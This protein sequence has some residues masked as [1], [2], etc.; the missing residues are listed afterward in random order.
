[1]P[2]PGFCVCAKKLGPMNS[3]EFHGGSPTPPYHHPPSPPKF[4]GLFP[5]GGGIECPFVPCHQSSKVPPPPPPPSQQHSWASLQISEAGLSLF[6]I[7]GLAAT[8]GVFRRCG[9]P[10]PALVAC[11]PSNREDT[12]LRHRQGGRKK[13]SDENRAGS[14]R[15]VGG[16]FSAPTLRLQWPSHSDGER[17]LGVLAPSDA[18]FVWTCRRW[19]P[20]PGTFYSELLRGPSLNPF[21]N[22]VGR[23]SVLLAACAEGNLWETWNGGLV[24]EDMDA[25]CAYLQRQPHSNR[26]DHHKLQPGSGSR[27]RQMPLHPFPLDRK[28]TT[29]RQVVSQEKQI[30]SPPPPLPPPSL[31]CPSQMHSYLPPLLC[32]VKDE[33][34]PRPLGVSSVRSSCCRSPFPLLHHLPSS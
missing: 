34:R 3:A 28:E 2:C 10:T 22:E 30:E 4:K 24:V 12:Y 32:H 23:Y 20:P 27:H 11:V 16:L 7:L 31:R 6:C 15:A 17:E 9:P 13:E 8:H 18:V 29:D 21:V 33:P 1:M 14:G 26:R 19:A 25:A 5:A